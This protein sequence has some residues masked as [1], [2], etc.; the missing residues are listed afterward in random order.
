MLSIRRLERILV[1]VLGICSIF[2][3]YNINEKKNDMVWISNPEIEEAEFLEGEVQM[4]PGGVH[5][6]IAGNPTKELYRDIYRNVCQLMEDLGVSWSKV[7]KLGEEE[8]GDERAVLIFCDDV[9]GSYVDLQELTVFIE[10]G[11]KAVLAAGVAEADQDAYLHPVLGI[12]EKTIK[13][14][15]NEY[16]LVPNF[17]PLQDVSMRYDGYNAS[18]WMDVRGDAKVYMQDKEKKVP[19]VYS[20]PYG[21]GKTLVINATFLSD[22]RCM[23]VLAAALGEILETFVYPMV[24]T[25]SIFLDNFPMVTYINDAACMKFYGRSTESFVRDVVWPVFQGIALRSDIR[26][27]SAVLSV[28]GKE[29]AFPAISESLFRTLGRSALQ[30][31]GELVYEADM[32]QK[33]EGYRNDPFMQQFEAVFPNY[34]I[35]SLA[36]A[37]VQEIPQSIETLNKEIHW[38]RGRLSAMDCGERMAVE[39]DYVVYPEATRGIDLED[40]NMFA[41]ASVLASHGMVSHTFDVN[42]LMVM[43]EGAAKWDMDKKKLAAYEQK[44]WKQ[45]GYLQKVT[46]SETGDAVKSYLGLEYGWKKQGNLLQITADGIRKGQPFWVRTKQRIEKAIG[47]DVIQVSEGYYCVYLQE[48]KASLFLE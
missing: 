43:E 13:E 47:A 16:L 40:G 35:H 17:F 3:L 8:L 31:G 36:M 37:D 14:N 22:S 38:V 19:M 11:G 48:T 26:Y 1:I 10:K 20:Y 34:Q 32:L 15:Y 45:T 28:S 24:G 44:V 18:L 5:F 41:I 7:Q 27:T 12:V 6:Y 39:T 2:L 4:D 33:E 46:L 21:E 42:Q 29:E 30:Y 25:E 23:G 9:L